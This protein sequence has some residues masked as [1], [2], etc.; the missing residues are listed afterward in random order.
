MKL[1]LTFQGLFAHIC[2]SCGTW[3]VCHRSVFSVFIEPYTVFIFA[4][5]LTVNPVHE[6]DLWSLNWHIHA[7]W[8]A[9]IETEPAETFL[10][11]QEPLFKKFVFRC[12]PDWRQKCR[13]L[14]TFCVCI[15]PGLFVFVKFVAGSSEFGK[16]SRT[17]SYEE[18]AKKGEKRQNQEE[19]CLHKVS[20]FHS[21]GGYNNE[22]AASYLIRAISLNW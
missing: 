22:S 1:L 10:A 9:V 11:F 12:T 5:R 16:S 3:I 6:A 4:G 21:H 18:I 15:H 2:A 8:K 20:T 13:F 19:S 7:L 17:F 14:D